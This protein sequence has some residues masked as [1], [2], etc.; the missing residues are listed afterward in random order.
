MKASKVKTPEIIKPHEG[1][2]KPQAWEAYTMAELGHWVHLL[3]TRAQ[4]RADPAKRAKDIED[5]Q[6]YLAMMQARLDAL[7]GA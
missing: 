7:K 1:D 4:H 6:A 2:Y 5:A 3:S